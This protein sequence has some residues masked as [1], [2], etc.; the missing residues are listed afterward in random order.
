MDISKLSEKEQYIY[1]L[2]GGG[3]KGERA[4][5]ERREYLDRSDE[6]LRQYGREKARMRYLPRKEKETVT[7]PFAEE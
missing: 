4:I 5:R 6:E 7:M 3:E 2:A 1:D